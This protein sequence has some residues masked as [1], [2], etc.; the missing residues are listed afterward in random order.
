MR[1]L[2]KLTDRL[3]QFGDKLSDQGQQNQQQPSRTLNEMLAE[4]EWTEEELCEWIDRLPDEHRRLIIDRTKQAANQGWNPLD[5]LR[6]ARIEYEAGAAGTSTGNSGSTLLD[7]W[8]AYE[9][10][11]VAAD[12]F[13]GEY[14]PNR[15]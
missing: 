14:K 7:Y 9:V 6:R 3:R 11:S 8:W 10:G 4:T 2:E 12:V 13:L 15:D 5:F 1:W